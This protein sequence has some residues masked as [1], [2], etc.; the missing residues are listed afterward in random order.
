MTGVATQISL[1]PEVMD[2]LVA[3]LGADLLPRLFETFVTELE[4]RMQTLRAAVRVGDAAAAGGEGHAIK[5]SAATFGMEALRLVS[6][7]IEQAGRAG[8]IARVRALEPRMLALCAAACDLMR[9]GPP[10]R[11]QV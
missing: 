10:A 5:S 9:A 11:W 4:S 3:D 2:Q 1:D 7:E 8:D 6:F